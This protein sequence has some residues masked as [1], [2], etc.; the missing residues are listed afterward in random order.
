M[1]GSG[2]NTAIRSCWMQGTRLAISPRPKRRRKN[3][4]QKLRMAPGKSA[5]HFLVRDTQRVRTALMNTCAHFEVRPLTNVR[6]W[7]F[8]ACRFVDFSVI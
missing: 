7:P 4:R 3:K 6:I 2:S 8:P 1:L 5:G